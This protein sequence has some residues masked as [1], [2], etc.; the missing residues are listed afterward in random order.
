VNIFYEPDIQSN[1]NVLGEDDSFHCIKVLRRQT[2]D[3]IYVLD[4]NGSRYECK[5]IE[6]NPKL[7][8]VTIL[9]ETISQLPESKCHIAIAPTKSMDR[10]EWFV[11]KSCEIGIREITP[12]L[13]KHSERKLFKTERVEKIITAALKQSG[14]FWRPKLNPLIT[15]NGFISENKNIAGQKFIASCINENKRKELKKSY[16]SDNNVIIMIGPEGDFDTAEI[17]AAIENG[18]ET[19]SLGNSRLRTET[20]A[21]VACHIIQIIN[22]K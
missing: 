2:N 20:A 18:F 14:S 21:L 12:I 7:C 10:V 3:L 4:G 13:C 1:G 6:P 5:I 11:E 16:F 22:E 15:F 8:K 9:R 17:K 19:V